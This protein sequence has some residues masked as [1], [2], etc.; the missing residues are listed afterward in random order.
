MCGEKREE[1]RGKRK[2]KREKG[3]EK[4][5]KRKEKREK[6]KEKRRKL[7]LSGTLHTLFRLAIGCNCT[8]SGHNPAQIS[9]IRLFQGLV[10]L[11]LFLRM[12]P[13]PNYRLPTNLDLTRRFRLSLHNT[14]DHIFRGYIKNTLISNG[15]SHEQTPK[16]RTKPMGRHHIFC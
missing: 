9:C 7:P 8:L 11:V 12:K 1:E 3:K 16:A 10:C 6:R 2:G 13:S 5:E 14:S 4:R 15:K